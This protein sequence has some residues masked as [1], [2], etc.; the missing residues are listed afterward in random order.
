M[1]WVFYGGKSVAQLGL[2]SPDDVFPKFIVNDLPAGL[3][4]LL[5]AGV[6]ASTM[7]ALASA[8]NALSTSTVADL[9][10]RFT[11]RPLPDSSV[12][13]HGRVWTL[14]WA[15]V[16]VVFASMFSTTKN[17]VIELGLGI[18]GYTYGALLGAFVLGI[19]VKR[20]RQADAVVAFVVTVVAMAVVILG[21][22]FSKG[23]ALLGL[24]FAKADSKTTFVL[25]YPWYT[26]LGVLITMVVGGLLA[27]RHRTPAVA[28]EPAVTPDPVAGGS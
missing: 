25:A 2:Q 26:V 4:G 11:H 5:I 12:L 6:L 28:D 19:L 10:Q 7:G 13:R 24:N 9:Y 18:T 3:S 21:V 27:L 20:A 8:L 16:F 15:L 22:K 1:L 23:G 14:V 17:S